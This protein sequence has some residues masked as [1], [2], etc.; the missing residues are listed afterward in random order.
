MVS[1]LTSLVVT[2][3]FWMSAPV[4]NAAAC[5]TMGLVARR[6]ATATPSPPMTNF[7]RMAAPS[8]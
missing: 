2:V 6:N 3:P 5:A 4:I 8:Q 7:E 1:F